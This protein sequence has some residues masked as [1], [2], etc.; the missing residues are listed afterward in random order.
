MWP[1]N[2]NSCIARLDGTD[3]VYVFPVTSFYG[4]QC[5]PLKWITDKRIN[6]LLLSLICWS[7]LSGGNFTDFFKQKNIMT[8]ITEAKKICLIFGT[9]AERRTGFEINGFCKG[10]RRNFIQQWF[11]TFL[12]SRTPKHRRKMYVPRYSFIKYIL[13]NITKDLIL[14]SPE[15]SHVPQVGNHCYIPISENKGWIRREVSHNLKGDEL[16][17]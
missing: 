3:R 4:I 11:T 9:G 7:K 13:F 12:S 6:H 17:E 15:I 14:I 10:E 16:D 5:P 8:R 2:K 1:S